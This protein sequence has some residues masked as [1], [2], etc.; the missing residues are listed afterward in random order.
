[1]TDRCSP[2]TCLVLPSFIPLCDVMYEY[3]EWVLSKSM[4]IFLGSHSVCSAVQRLLAWETRSALGCR[5]LQ[6]FPS[7]HAVRDFERGTLLV[8]FLFFPSHEMEIEALRRL[9]IP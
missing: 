6:A 8:A 7:R 3:T 9:L 2:K 4:F 1:M 5:L